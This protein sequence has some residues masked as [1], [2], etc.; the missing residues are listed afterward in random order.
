MKAVSVV[1][2]VKEISEARW[3]RAEIAFYKQVEVTRLGS[4]LYLR[5][6]IV[7]AIKEIFK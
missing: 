6:G 7:A 4:I 2:I 3:K 5:A 1:S